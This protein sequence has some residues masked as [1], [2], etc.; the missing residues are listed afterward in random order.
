MFVHPDV[1]EVPVIDV[2]GVPSATTLVIAMRSPNGCADE[3]DTWIDVT[4]DDSCGFETS[5]QVADIHT[6]KFHPDIIRGVGVIGCCEEGARML[7][8]LAIRSWYS[9]A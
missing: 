9:F 2:V 4:T 8:I 1:T 6:Q 5:V 7:I 3:P